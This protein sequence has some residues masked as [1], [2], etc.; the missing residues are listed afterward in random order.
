[1][2]PCKLAILKRRLLLIQEYAVRLEFNGIT[3]RVSCRLLRWQSASGLLR[4]RCALG[5]QLDLRV[6]RDWRTDN[7]RWKER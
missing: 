5:G 2:T 7:H 3:S 4:V 1:M 6:S